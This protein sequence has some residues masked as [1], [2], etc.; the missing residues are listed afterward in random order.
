MPF[1]G[2]MSEHEKAKMMKMWDQREA[3]VMVGTVAVG[4]GV[5]FGGINVVVRAE[6]ALSLE[7]IVQEMGRCARGVGG[8]GTYVLLYA[9]R[10]YSSAA[11]LV[12]Q[13]STEEGMKRGM[14]RLDR[15]VEALEGMKGGGCFFAAT[16]E[17]FGEPPVKCSG[18][19]KCQGCAGGLD[20]ADLP[21]RLYE[22]G[23]YPALLPASS[24]TA[25]VPPVLDPRAQA[26]FERLM[27]MRA[28]L[29]A[30][31]A[32]RRGV[33]RPDPGAIACTTTLSAIAVAEASMQHCD[34]AE[35]NAVV[36]VRLGVSWG[37][38]CSVLLVVPLSQRTSTQH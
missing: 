9:S 3:R 8:T 7:D 19:F 6:L 33:R 23:K 2:Q 18:P 37:M 34:V 5:N 10:D 26:V 11:R 30:D 35:L 4:M 21:P 28:Q 31:V 16:A 13:G 24:S 32:A 38:L 17:Y 14:R 36:R 20:L 22:R 27:A 29:A 1:H 25:P 12:K 15:V